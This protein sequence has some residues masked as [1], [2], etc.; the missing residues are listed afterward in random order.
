MF[1]FG[2]GSQGAVQL[3]LVPF[4][5]QHEVGSL[6]T[7]LVDR[8]QGRQPACR[9]RLVPVDGVHACLHLL[10]HGFKSLPFLSLFYE[11]LFGSAYAHCGHHVETF[12]NR[13]QCLLRVVVD[14]LLQHLGIGL[15]ALWH[16]AHL[17]PA[18]MLELRTQAR[19][20]FRHLVDSAVSSSEVVG[21]FLHD[22]PCLHDAH[23]VGATHQPGQRF[24]DVIIELGEQGRFADSLGQNAHLGHVCEIIGLEG[25][26]LQ[27]HHRAEV[28]LQT[29]IAC[30]V[31]TWTE[32]AVGELCIRIAQEF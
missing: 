4:G 29:V 12:G 7:C 26:G 10:H 15:I 19:L 1:Q 8:L 27:P 28:A 16:D 20:L 18:G 6:F 31:A 32:Q 24:A 2:P 5:C 17:V 9:N 13:A 11:Q 21:R 22:L 3:L 23:V 30:I 25:N 14:H